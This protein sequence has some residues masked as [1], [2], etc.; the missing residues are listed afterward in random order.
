MQSLHKVICKRRMQTCSLFNFQLRRNVAFS[1]SKVLFW[2]NELANHATPRKTPKKSPQ[3]DMSRNEAYHKEEPPIAKSTSA[4]PETKE[5]DHKHNSLKIYREGPNT[6][7]GELG[8]KSKSE[9]VKRH[10]KFVADHHET[11]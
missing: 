7:S 2:K 8:P 6:E 9:E 4:P 10:N 11:L 3:A 5:G 1:R